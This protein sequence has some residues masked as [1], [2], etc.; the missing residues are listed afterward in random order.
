MCLTLGHVVYIC[1]YNYITFERVSGDS[2]RQNVLDFKAC[3]SYLRRPLVLTKSLFRQIAPA[4]R[5]FARVLADS[6]RQNLLDF[7]TCGLYLR[8]Q[9]VLIKSLFRQIARAFRTFARV[10]GDSGRQNVLAFWST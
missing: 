9:I 5:T 6:G 2:G 7:K 3:G 1:V 8:C 4:L 10:S